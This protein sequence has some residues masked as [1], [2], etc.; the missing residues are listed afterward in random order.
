MKKFFTIYVML[1]LTIS[2]T[3]QFQKGNKVL[4]FGINFQ[5][6]S[7]EINSAAVPQ[8]NKSTGFNVSVELGFAKKEN[9]L[10]G[11]FLNS[12]YGV[13]KTE[14]PSQPTINYKNDNYNAGAGYFTR[15]YKPLGKNF[16]VFGEG[17]AGFNYSQQ[18]NKTN[19][20]HFNPKQ[21]GVNA[22]LYPGL[23]YKWNQRFLLELRFADIVTV[24]Y[25]Q[26]TV[27]A[28]NSKKDIQRNF[29]FGSNLGLGYLSNIGIGTKWILK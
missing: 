6:N 3:A 7:N 28:A 20:S 23:A 25:S 9:R 8:I 4:G 5:S 19:S 21:F 29:S 22:G 24:G 13:S 14:Y 2:A 15:Y 11:F 27:I 18:N 1:I 17:R 16:F 12:G 10:N 26:G